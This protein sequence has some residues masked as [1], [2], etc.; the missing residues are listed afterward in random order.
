MS[1][2]SVLVCSLKQ[3]KPNPAIYLALAGFLLGLLPPAASAKRLD[4]SPHENQWRMGGQNLSD[5]RNQSVKVAIGPSNVSQLV[6]KWVFT[7][8]GDVSATPAVVNDVVYF[9]DWV[10]D[11]YAVNAR[12]G[13][14]IWSHRIADWTGIPGDWARNDPALN[15]DAII[16][17]DQGGALATFSNGRLS[18]PGARVVAVRKKTGSLLWSTQ[19]DSFAA[20]AIT[21]SP[22]IF[23]NI[24]Y[25]GVAS[26]T[27]ES[28]SASFP[29]YPAVRFEAAS[30][31]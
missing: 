23:N 10:G 13:A 11:F 7:T 4:P 15:G 24:V 28:L 1:K 26:L 22:V 21:S 19:V 14:L 8:A 5:T 31:P 29:D 12:S 27:E 6:T 2:L 20:A 3:A 30:W 18:G 16:L 17:G 25:V 9:P